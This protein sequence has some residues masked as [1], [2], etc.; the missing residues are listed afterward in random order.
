MRT[1]L[2]LLLATACNVDNT[3]NNK[4]H[5][6]VHFDTGGDTDIPIDTDD[7]DAPPPEECNGYDDDGDGEVDEGFPDDDGNGRVDCLDADCPVMDFGAAGS[8]VVNDECVGTTGSGGGPEVPDPWNVKVKWT[9]TAPSGYA[10]NSN[11]WMTPVIGN[12]NDDNGDGVIDEDDSPEVVISTAGSPGV[13]VAIDGATGREEWS[14]AGGNGYADTLIADVD[15]DGYPDVISADSSGRTIALEG[16]GTL[17]WTANDMLVSLN[18]MIQNVADL[19]EDGQPEVI[20][21]S[22]VLSG[23]DGSTE[24]TMSVS[25]TGG[26]T[27]R[28]PAI[29]D[30]DNDGDQ[31]IALQGALYDSDG[32]LLWDSGEN[33]PYGFWPVIIQADTDPEAEIG[34]V[35]THWSLFEDDGTMIYQTTYNSTAQ[36]GP[37]CAGDFDGDGTAEVAWPAYQNFVMYELDGTRVWSVP[38]DDT[39]GLA[40]C[41]GYDLNNDGALEI[42]F[43]D[44]TSFTIFDGATGAELYVDPTHRSP[45]IFEYPTVADIDHDGHAEILVAHYG[46]GVALTAY[47]NNGTGWPAAGST[48]NVH[49]FAITNINA[50]GSVPQHPEASWTKYNVYR[51]RVAA[52]DPSTPDL[53]VSVTDVCVADCDYGPVIVGVQVSNAGGSDIDAGASLGLYAIDSTGPRLVATYSLPAIA[54]GEA[55]AGIEFDLTPADVGQFGFQAVVDGADSLSECVETNNEDTWAD[56]WCP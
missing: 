55:L 14:Y 16:D 27:Y 44:Q 36:P 47:E 45:T 13:I 12:L 10:G 34:F 25:G 52:D 2:L 17:K 7:T 49:D 11:S 28:L 32:S 22:K 30:V 41:S 18:Y 29:A 26:Q 31:E 6:Q 56:A 39:S 33:G 53:Q 21:D 20:H 3:I 9:F 19:D 50:D 43:A 24:F 51:A 15:A 54:S 23:M 5:D 46:S 35:G 38:M 1:S 8:V 4:D 37:P 42:L 40:G 48:W